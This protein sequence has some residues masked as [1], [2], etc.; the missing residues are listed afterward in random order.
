MITIVDYGVGNLGSIANMI[1][2]VGGSC[3][4]T[5]DHQ[6]IASATKI[7]LPG[8]GHFRLGMQELK[9]RNLIDPL[10]SARDQGTWVLGICLG[11]Q[12]M[13]RHSEEGDAEG[14]GWFD[15]DTRRFPNEQFEGKP[16][17]IPHM[18]WNRIRTRNS[19]CAM[20][21]PSEDNSR[22]Y[23]VNSYFV[24]G[25]GDRRCVCTTSYG[26]TEFSSG[27]AQDRT[28]GFQFHPEKSH[29]YGMRLMRHFVELNDA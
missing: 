8:V 10:N 17:I 28:F 13:T 26:T 6:S 12:L 9:A 4:I 27:I 2:R 11:M 20:L 16:L 29:K 21:P 1:H 18:G 23:F 14:L 19:G 15:L 24:D 3:S 7:I 25:A 5:S 22:F